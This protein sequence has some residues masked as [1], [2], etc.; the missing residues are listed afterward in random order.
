[1][2]Y[3]KTRNWKK[4]IIQS[5]QRYKQ[6]KTASWVAYG[7]IQSTYKIHFNFWSPSRSPLTMIELNPTLILLNFLLIILLP[8]II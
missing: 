8:K 7:A 3:K 4:L 6:L 2:C 5:Y 1:M